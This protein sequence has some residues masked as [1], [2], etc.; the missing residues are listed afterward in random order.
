[1]ELLTDLLT[2]MM[3]SDRLISV[4]LDSSRSDPLYIAAARHRL[5]KSLAKERVRPEVNGEAVFR[6]S[7][8]CSA[9]KKISKV[10]H[11]RRY[12]CFCS[13]HDDERAETPSLLLTKIK[14]VGSRA[15]SRKRTDLC[16]WT[17]LKK[18]MNEIVDMCGKLFSCHYA[19]N[20]LRPMNE[21]ALRQVPLT[22]CHG[23]L[24]H[25]A[26]S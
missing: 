6:P 12:F 24:V 15:E 17:I 14:D 21:G 5:E 13:R 23:L 2:A 16:T 3:P 8:A 4:S 18:K 22:E 11:A 10:E 19:S 26:P 1:M 7:A 20:L 25:T 9:G